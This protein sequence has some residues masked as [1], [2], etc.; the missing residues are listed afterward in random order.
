MDA[1]SFCM[2]DMLPAD[3]NATLPGPTLSSKA[4]V[5]KIGG[6]IGILVKFLQILMSGFH[7]EN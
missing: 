5:L 1:R 4:L 6:L 3:A 7:P 2:Y